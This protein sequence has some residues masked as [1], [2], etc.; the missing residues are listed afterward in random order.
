MDTNVLYYG[1]NLEILRKYIPDE[2]VDLIYIDPPFNSNQAYNVFLPESNGTLSQAQIRAFD[3]TWHW[4]DETRQTYSEIISKA[5]NDRIV[6]CIENFR[7]LLGDTNMM[8]YLTMMTPRLIELYRVLKPTGSFYLHC[9]PTASHYLKVLSDTVLGA[10][11]FHSEIIWRRTNSHNKITRQYGPIHDVILFYTKTDEFVFHPG[12]QPYT[13]AYI[14]GR[15]KYHDKRGKYQHNYLTGPGVRYGESGELWRGFNPTTVGRHWAIPLSL[16][17]FLPNEGEGMLTLEMLELL[18]SQ[19]LI[20]FPKKGGGQP[21]YKQYMGDGVPYQD[22]WAYQPNT[23]GILFDSDECID[24]DVKY[25]ENEDERL[26]FQTQKPMGL[27]ARIIRTSSNENDVVL[28]AFAGC[29]TTIAVAQHLKRRWIGIDITHLA[30]AL[31]RHRLG[32]IEY[33]VKG[34]P[35]DISG[36]GA[37]AKQNRLD[38]QSWALGL[39]NAKPKNPE[40]KKGSD[41]GIDGVIRLEDIDAKS[42][43]PITHR[44]IIQV[45]SGKVSVRDIRDLWGVIEREQAIIGVLITLENPTKPMVM[46]ADNAGYYERWGQKYPKIQIRTIEELFQNKGIEY[47]NLKN[48]NFKEQ[49]KKIE[50]TSEI[51]TEF[52]L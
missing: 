52:A 2:S 30:I 20:V 15:F 31:I 18:Y 46:E 42:G 27:L 24:E 19:D 6:K 35:V 16:R 37:L 38:F 11:Q 43:K 39:V 40:M 32:D 48:T 4:T 12:Y 14:E 1:D 9:D 25:L 45:K 13:K 10:Q 36:A 7:D 23:Q 49:P 28:D 41:A 47:P 44:I 26:G 50:S 22:I 5:P 51:Q 21:M 3:D 17:K 33:K 34:V 8:A 29:G